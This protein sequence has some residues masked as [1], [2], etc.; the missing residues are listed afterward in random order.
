MTTQKKISIVVIIVLFLLGLANLVKVFATSPKIR[1]AVLNSALRQ[2][3]PTT[4]STETAFLQNVLGFNKPRT[5]LVLFLNNT[6]LRP[7]G[8]FIG[9][10]A[11]VTV[12]KAIPHIAIVSGSETIDN[13]APDAY[14]SP[15]TPLQK[16]LN[17]AKW[18]FRDSN[19]SPDF[20]VST[21]NSLKLFRL[22]GGVG[23]DTIDG[24]IGF[25]P[26]VLEKILTIIGPTTVDG[27][28]FTTANATE[29]LE[30]EV[31]HGYKERGLAF[32][33]R[34]KILVNLV[35]AMVA[36]MV[37]GVVLH[38]SEYN[39]LLLSLLREKQVVV[40][41]TTPSEQSD[42]IT[43]GW[44]GEMKSAP[45]DYLLWA[46]ANLG[47]LKTDVVIDRALT[48]TF[49]PIAKGM[50]ATATMNYV[51]TGAFTWRTT[52]Y[53]DYA[54]IFVPLGSRLVG[55]SGA[56][57]TDRSTKVGVVDQG[58]ENGK[59]WFGAFIS[60]EPGKSGALSFTYD[61]PPSVTEAIQR[62]AYQ[63]LIQK[64]IGTIA[65]QLTLRLDFGKPVQGATPGEGAAKHGDNL[66]DLQTDL[67]TD[68]N[69][70][71]SL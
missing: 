20:T 18:Q 39:A 48:Y 29:K 50:R 8:G 33:E 53:R 65:P 32:S 30:Y 71:V 11:V 14:L 26:V 44:A 66:Y 54:R 3:V 64:Q 49:A 37:A 23:A 24:V 4:T 21:V 70:T 15:P 16:Y 58:I 13:A 46:D 63:V 47:A 22:E 67:R 34:K 31:E 17:I 41:S 1:G 9:S 10:Y 45:T 52:R 35:H 27:R 28:E 69:F 7:G 55:S 19:W 36:R 5:Y 51:N 40:Y 43:Q 62:G 12:D 2:F 60:V 57:E 38:W 59:Q 25:T 42:F 61:L 68:Q 6:E 56:M